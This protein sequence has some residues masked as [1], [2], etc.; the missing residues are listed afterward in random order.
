VQT[1]GTVHPNA[2]LRVPLHFL[3]DYCL[4]CGTKFQDGQRCPIVKGGAA[5]KYRAIG[6]CIDEDCLQEESFDI[7]VLYIHYR[8]VDPTCDTSGEWP[9]YMGPPSPLHGFAK[10]MMLD[11]GVG[12]VGLHRGHVEHWSRRDVQTIGA[13]YGSVS[14]NYGLVG[15]PGLFPYQVIDVRFYNLATPLPL[16][17]EWPTTE[18]RYLRGVRRVG[19]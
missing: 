18:N 2:A 16:T 5:A 3:A 10:V 17:G 13:V 12:F 14:S 4:R 1:N 6:L 11:N 8:R 15:P 19:P 9:V 7:P